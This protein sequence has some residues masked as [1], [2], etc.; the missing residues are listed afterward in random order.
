MVAGLAANVATATA[1]PLSTHC[2]KPVCYLRC[3]L[4]FNVKGDHYQRAAAAAA[5]AWAQTIHPL[6]YVRTHT[7]A[8]APFAH[9]LRRVNVAPLARERAC[10]GLRPACR[11][12]KVLQLHLVTCSAK[13]ALGGARTHLQEHGAC[14]HLVASDAHGAAEAKKQ[15]KVAGFLLDALSAPAGLLRLL[16]S[17]RGWGAGGRCAH[18]QQ[19]VLAHRNGQHL[20]FFTY[21]RRLKARLELLVC[22][23]KKAHV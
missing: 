10:S 3:V 20:C 1:A 21:G 22:R 15:G 12:R 19:M 2:T 5:W 17:S 23:H 7:T 4:C 14:H 13:A 11:R 16:S 18:K 8:S 6:A 9:V